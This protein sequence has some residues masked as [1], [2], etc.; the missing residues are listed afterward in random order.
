MVSVITN[1][2]CSYFTSKK[3]FSN[4][5]LLNGI[6]VL[7][8]LAM[9]VFFKYTALISNLI[10]GF[11]VPESYN[12]LL[13]IPLPIGISF[14]TFQGISL[15]IDSKKN[16]FSFNSE[17]PFLTCLLK[18]ATY[19]TFFP[20]L[21]AGP[22]LKPHYFISQITQKTFKKIRFEKA[23]RYLILGYFFKMVIGDNLAALTTTFMTD[24]SYKYLNS[25]S[26]F[27]F[28]FSYGI[29]VFADFAG[30]SFIAIGLGTLFGY[31]LKDNFNRPYNSESLSEFWR[32]W[33]I[34]L[35]AWF[36]EYLYMPFI[37]QFRHW[38]KISIFLGIIITF[39]LSGIWHGDSINF[40]L[41][42]FYFGVCLCLELFFKGLKKKLGFNVRLINILIVMAIWNFGLTLFYF[43]HIEHFYS[44]LKSLLFNWNVFRFNNYMEI[45]TVLLIIPILLYHYYEFLPLKFKKH[46][47]SAK[48]II[49]GIMLY[50]IIFNYGPQETFIYFRF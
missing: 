20:Q 27:I 36:N 40:A 13:T 16:H 42:G 35:Y 18:V 31:K 7:V 41:W 19:I 30:Y 33:H 4:I 45:Y 6:G 15:L 34:T 24:P 23:I 3:T 47:I 48:G 49:Y 12:W 32:R 5:L 17:S 46:A 11:D 38:G 2:Y 28:L 9:L 26:N 21:I 37:I 25:L 50:F 44:F 14:Y 39:S 10:F 29:R 43:E 8:N 22:I 1:A